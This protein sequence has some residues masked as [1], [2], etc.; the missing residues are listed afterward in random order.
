M[1][2]SETEGASMSAG[3]RDP[4]SVSVGIGGSVLEGD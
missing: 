3:E 2:L 4:E 1:R